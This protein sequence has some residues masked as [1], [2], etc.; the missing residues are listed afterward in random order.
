MSSWTATERAAPAPPAD[1]RTSPW[2]FQ[3]NVSAGQQGNHQTGWPGNIYLRVF[4]I[5]G[6]N[7]DQY[8]LVLPVRAALCWLSPY[9]PESP[10]QRPKKTPSSTFTKP[11]APWTRPK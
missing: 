9:L 6:N 11:P 5:G 3:D 8:E 2:D 4:R 1:P 10:E 7:C